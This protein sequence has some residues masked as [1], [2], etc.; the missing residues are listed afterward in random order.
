[1]V[2]DW[3]T[4]DAKMTWK[5]NSPNFNGETSHYLEKLRITVL[6]RVEN[7][8]SKSSVLH[9]IILVL[10]RLGKMLWSVDFIGPV[11]EYP[12]KTNASKYG[13]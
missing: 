8:I 7:Y 2:P 1:M 12:T 13:F 6:K 3:K 10:P 4:T 9:K 11:D 5:L